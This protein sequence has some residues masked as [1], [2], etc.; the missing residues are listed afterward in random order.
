MT[1]R[2]RRVGAY[3]PR[4]QAI[5]ERLASQIAPAIE[6]A[7]LY[8]RLQASIKEKRV[9]D[10]IAGI[11]TSTLDIDQ[12]YEKFA[13]EMQ[14]LVDYDRIAIHTIDQKAGTSTLKYLIG[15]A[16]SSRSFGTTIPLGPSRTREALKTG[17]PLRS[18]DTT[19]D[20]Q[21][22]SDHEYASN[23]MRASIVIPLICKGCVI[24]ALSLRSRRAGAYG[25]KEEVILERLASQIAPAIENSRLHHETLRG[26][27]ALRESEERYRAVA[28]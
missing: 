17:L 6:N 4:Q 25:P 16:R 19:I 18:D 21:F 24:G 8:L 1:L 7:K 12:V 27:E 23:G 20:P 13:L 26:E 10:E 3:G 15:P 11:I 28:Y 2:S 9:V 14:K 5:L 22:P